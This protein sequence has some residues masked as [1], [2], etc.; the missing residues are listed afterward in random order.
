[1]FR[2]RNLSSLN[3]LN[4]KMSPVWWEAGV[5]TC[6]KGKK[7]ELVSVNFDTRSEAILDDYRIGRVED[8][9]RTSPVRRYKM[10]I[11]VKEVEVGWGWLSRGLDRVDVDKYA[12]WLWMRGY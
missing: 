3:I 11:R 1:V 8:G 10:V 5:Y 7:S 6:A 12:K 2:Q 4:T 9:R